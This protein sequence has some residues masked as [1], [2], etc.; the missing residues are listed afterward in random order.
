MLR[1]DPIFCDDVIFF[2][3]EPG[4]KRRAALGCGLSRLG[5]PLRKT[6]CDERIMG[7]PAQ[8]LASPEAEPQQAGRQIGRAHSELQSLMR[9]SS[10]VLCL[11]K[12]KL[13]HYSHQ[14]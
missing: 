13:Q 4:F 14:H 1:I 8:K 9:I 7:A 3:V 12:K 11:N 6:E 10:A 2:V 5:E